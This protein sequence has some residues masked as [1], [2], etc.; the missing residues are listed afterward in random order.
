MISTIKFNAFPYYLSQYF[1]ILY[2][3]IPIGLSFCFPK[4]T[5]K[6][7][8]FS[9]S[10]KYD[11]SKDPIIFAHVS[12]TH[13]NVFRPKS[14]TTFYKTI[15]LI[16][17]YSPDF[18]IHT[19]DIVDN[20]DSIKIP[21]YAIQNQDSWK[22][23]RNGTSQINNNI[24]IIEVAGNH[25]MFGVKSYNSPGNYIL[26]YGHSFSRNT[27]EK[28]EN[29]QIRTFHLKRSKITV[30]ALNPYKFPFPHS[31]HIM[32]MPLSTTTLDLLEN[33]V[34]KSANK[35]I[36]ISHFPIGSIESKKSSNGKTLTDIFDNTEKV[37]GYLSGHWH[38]KGPSSFHDGKFGVDIVAA[39][40][41]SREKFGIVCVDNDGISWSTVDINNP[42]KGVVS[43]PIPADQLSTSSI[44][45]DKENAEIRVVMFDESTE[46]KIEF[47]VI[48]KANSK[49]VKDGFLTYKKTLINGRTLYTYPLSEC[50]DKF[51]DFRVN[52]QGDFVG[53]TD[54]VVKESVTFP[55]K[56]V[57]YFTGLYAAL[58]YIYSI[59]VIILLFITVAIPFNCFGF[60][61]KLD[62]IEE[63]IETSVGGCLSYWLVSIFGGFLLVRSRFVSLPLAFKIFGFLAVIYSIFGPILF[64]QIEDSIGFVWLFGYVF[65][66]KV[67]IHEDGVVYSLF[68]LALVCAPVVLLSSSFGV[69][70]WY[71]IQFFDFVVFAICVGLDVLLLVG[72]IYN[73]AGPNLTGVSIAFILVPFVFFVMLVVWL[74]A[75]RNGNGCCNDDDEE[76]G[77]RGS[78]FY[79]KALN[80]D[81]Y[82][83]TQ[84][85]NTL[86]T[87]III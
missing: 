69:K 55:K 56:E 50:I 83:L 33:E 10:A 9:S 5:K 80:D 13:I 1:W 17:S 25:D 23:Y 74:S 19:G 37:T 35:V 78:D 62:K 41:F 49:T 6:V 20:Y 58:P 39:S 12:D 51:G 40:T 31:P 63:W 34:E 8:I 86:P 66:K 18:I 30:I 68:Y 57:G 24:P 71:A 53:S 29:F 38:P 84:N 60:Q 65:G 70:D 75:F 3:L 46:L 54:F 81:E 45:N 28:D 7:T 72:F 11:A 2:I 77:G 82:D 21:R 27:T 67:M 32:N 64:T 87:Q 15:E 42:I 47:K 16:N 79:K 36:I 43:Y 73:C 52:F 76:E 22:I 26:D 85:L 4:T 61:L 44:F 59:F 48:D 14:V